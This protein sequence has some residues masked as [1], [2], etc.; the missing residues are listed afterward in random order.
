[1]LGDEEASVV[2]GDVS[3]DFFTS[4]PIGD[5]RLGKVSGHVKVATRSGTVEV[6]EAGKGAELSTTG[7][8]V[9]I[10]SVKGDLVAMTQGGDVKVGSCTGEARLETLGGDVSLGSAGGAVTAKTSGGDV[11]LRRVK[12][13]VKAET[14]GGSITCE[15]AVKE[16]AA[17]C[18]LVTHGGDVTLTLPSN[19]KAD[20]DVRV[21]G[22]DPYG[23]YVVSE[24]PEI[25]VSKRGGQGRGSLTAEGKLNGGGTKVTI[26]TTS[27]TVTLRKGPPA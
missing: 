11:T 27:G 7:G 18:S 25:V 16:L 6:A 5:V 17:A 23:D 26:R 24:F 22:V 9:S 8:D 13:P 3:G 10:D 1:V 14:G 21:S 2:M 19:L 15:L 12:G 20:L 4:V